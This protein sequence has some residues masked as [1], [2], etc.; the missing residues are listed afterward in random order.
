MARRALPPLCGALDNFT[1]NAFLHTSFYA[2]RIADPKNRSRLTRH[3]FAYVIFPRVHQRAPLSDRLASTP[4][5]GAPP[6]IYHACQRRPS[7]HAS[8]AAPGRPHSR[9][10][11]SDFRFQISDFRFQIPDPRSQSFVGRPKKRAQN[12]DFQMEK[13]L[14]IFAT[15]VNS[16]SS[17]GALQN[18]GSPRRLQNTQITS[19][20][21]CGLGKQ[22]SMVFFDFWRLQDHRKGHPTCALQ[23]SEEQKA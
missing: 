15:D 17:D 7:A 13:A 11:I 23:I 14:Q 10:P 3:D 8:A 20:R 19:H 4:H 18:S 2:R 21:A 1:L 22:K 12:P 16:E 5:F 6:L 9:K